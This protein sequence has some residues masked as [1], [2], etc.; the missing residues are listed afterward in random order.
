MSRCGFLL[1]SASEDSLLIWDTNFDISNKS[2][3]VNPAIEIKI[4]DFFRGLCLLDLQDKTN[5]V[6]GDYKGKIYIIDYIKEKLLFKLT[7][8]GE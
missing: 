4:D 3:I 7:T 8:H 6:C 1:A 2:E 5:I